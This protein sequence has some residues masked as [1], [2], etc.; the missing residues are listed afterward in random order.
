MIM[1]SEYV[2]ANLCHWFLYSYIYTSS[3]PW[4]IT[5]G[6]INYFIHSSPCQYEGIHFFHVTFTTW[7]D[8]TDDAAQM[9]TCL[10]FLSIPIPVGRFDS[11]RIN[12]D[13][14]VVLKNLNLTEVSRIRGNFYLRKEMFFLPH[15]PWLSGKEMLMTYLYSKQLFGL[16]EE[17]DWAWAV[18]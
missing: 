1:K 15:S 14:H 4:G 3:P 10:K 2:P 9:K 5:Y 18:S 7:Q 13:R 12:S 16:L 6:F 11:N 17:E 8:G